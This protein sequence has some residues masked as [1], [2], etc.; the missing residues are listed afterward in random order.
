[1]QTSRLYLIDLPCRGI[2]NNHLVHAGKGFKRNPDCGDP[3]TQ[4]LQT[5]LNAHTVSTRLLPHLSCSGMHIH[6][7]QYMRNLLQHTPPLGHAHTSCHTPA[8]SN[9]HLC[10]GMQMILVELDSV[11]SMLS[12]PL[13]HKL[14]GMLEAEVA[15]VM[16]SAL[17]AGHMP[18]STSCECPRGLQ[19]AAGVYMG[20]QGAARGYLGL[21]GSTWGCMGLQGTAG[22]YMG[23][24]GAARGCLG[25]QGATWGCRGL[26][27]VAGGCTGLQGAAWGCRGLNEAYWTLANCCNQNSKHGLFIGPC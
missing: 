5:L 15:T 1:M 21:Q 2:A 18:Q 3:V 24:H 4:R 9:A 13:M 7:A 14:G 16:A 17:P 25:L 26:L 19:R 22:G 11:L 20:L 6:H 23:L 8:Y 27:G 10:Y 12:T